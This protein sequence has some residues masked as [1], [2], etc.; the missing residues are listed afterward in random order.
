MCYLSLM[1]SIT[2]KFYK[3]IY[4]GKQNDFGE[5]E[6]GTQGFLVPFLQNKL[7]ASG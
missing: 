1:L 3:I 6:V 7:V 4:K 2:E 5:T